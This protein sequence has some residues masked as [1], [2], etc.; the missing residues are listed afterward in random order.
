[1]A[2][3]SDDDEEVFSLAGKIT[4]VVKGQDAHI[5]LGAITGAFVRALTDAH[6]QDALNVYNQEYLEAFRAFITYATRGPEG[7]Q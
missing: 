3:L 1:M 5:A 6:G 4:E 2:N 7:L